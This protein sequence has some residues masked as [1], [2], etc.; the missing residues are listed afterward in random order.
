MN[1]P[2]RHDSNERWAEFEASG[3]FF[4]CYYCKRPVHENEVDWIRIHYPANQSEPSQ[5]V[6]EPFHKDCVRIYFDSEKDDE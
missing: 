2:N 3:S 6:E 4:D 1:Q 5:L